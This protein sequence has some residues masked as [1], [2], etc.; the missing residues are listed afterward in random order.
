MMNQ[1]SEI[2]LSNDNIIIKMAYTTELKVNAGEKNLQ[3]E[4]AKLCFPKDFQWILTMLRV[5]Y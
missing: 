3:N 2:A 4:T 1:I 5:E